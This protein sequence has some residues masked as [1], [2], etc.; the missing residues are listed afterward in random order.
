[1]LRAAPDY[2]GHRWTMWDEISPWGNRKIAGNPLTFELYLDLWSP[3][4]RQK[5]HIGL[6][7]DSGIFRCLLLTIRMDTEFPS[8]FLIWAWF[9]KTLITLKS[10]H[11]E[12]NEYP[13]L[14]MVE[15]V[16]PY[17]VWLDLNV[18]QLLDA[19]CTHCWL[20]GNQS[21]W[22]R[23]Q[24]QVRRCLTWVK[25]LVG[26]IRESGRS[27]VYLFSALVRTRPLYS[28]LSGVLKVWSLDQQL[29]HPG[30]TC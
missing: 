21:Q 19:T 28:T 4:Q 3:P 14:R 25:M 12:G 26:K 2:C 22:P 24:H 5:Y 30:R 1:M 9:L 17:Q 20:G 10:Q 6:E 13:A 29:Q 23:R 15:Q 7:R 27:C 16:S 18:H 8:S 11:V